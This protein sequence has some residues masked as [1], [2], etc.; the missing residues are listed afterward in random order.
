[1]QQLSIINC[2]IFSSSYIA[3]YIFFI[4]CRHRKHIFLLLH[5]Y[6]KMQRLLITIIT[7]VTIVLIVVDYTSASVINKSSLPSLSKSLSSLSSSSISPIKTLRNALCFT[8]INCQLLSSYPNI[9]NAEQQQQQQY[10]LK[11]GRL[12]V[13]KQKSNCISSSSIQPQNIV[14]VHV[15]QGFVDWTSNNTAALLTLLALLVL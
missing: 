14:T 10:G 11:K 1:M 4:I 13:C 8:V 6:Q 5:T 7:I 12:L 15:W 9:A 3:V 2:I